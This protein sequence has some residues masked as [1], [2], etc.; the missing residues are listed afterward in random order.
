MNTGADT[1]KKIFTRY[2]N[3]SQPGSAE[4]TAMFN[5]IQQR[6]RAQFEK[7]FPDKLAPRTVVIIPSLSLDEEI[8][9]KITG[10]IFYE[11]RLLCL[12]MLLRMPLTKVIYVTSVPIDHVII[13]YYLHL[14]PGITG[15]HAMQRL[16]MLSC[17]D[18]SSK[19][20]T[21]KILERPRLIQRIKQNIADDTAAHLTCFNITSLEKTLAVQ[22]GIPLFGTD[23]D[24]FYEGTKSGSRKIFKAAGVRLPEGFEDLKT[25]QDVVTALAALKKNK[26]GLQKAVIKMNEGF[27]GEGNAIY[28]YP[29]FYGN[30]LME[31]NIDESMPLH[32]RIS[33]KDLSENLFFE[34]IYEMG[35]I[36]EEF[37]DADIKTSP[38]VQCLINPLHE[39]EVL[40]THDQL[41][42]GEDGQI[43]IGASF[44]ANGEYNIS[45]AKEGKKIAQALE[46]K[47][48][49]GRFAID[50]ISVKQND[51]WMH[52]A[53]EIN[54][55]KGG[56][57]HPFFMLQFLTDGVYNAEKGEYLTASGNKRFYFSTDN[58][59]KE[60]YKG[61]T[62]HDL[63]DIAMF[64]SL[65]YDG[66]SQ[67]GVMFHLV[68]ALSQYG[69][70]GLVCIGDTPQKA[71]EYYDK[72]MYV[73]DNECSE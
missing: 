39:V 10:H 45:L 52:Y 27:S 3:I 8:L 68:G 44:P 66:A 6:F 36:V 47:G 1:F 14:L 37:I 40:S 65:M 33:A 11:E 53:I 71:K 12:L 19:P 60:C 58:V 35:G 2:I 38:S 54:L 4:E 9:S 15:I 64:H 30:G 56:T 25:R 48:A 23:P 57:T 41:L 32:L 21:K 26:P 7:I 61:L 13:D 46:K 63:F 17:Y 50:F 34:K 24:L 55:R 70:L 51:E 67:E 28:Y 18:A 5:D 31:K 72:V 20:L 29:D 69:K 42:G 16:T 73:L 62:P 49:L 43:F 22:L 59:S